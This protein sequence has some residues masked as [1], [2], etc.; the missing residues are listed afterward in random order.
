M[1]K[2]EAVSFLFFLITET[3][4]TKAWSFFIQVTKNPDIINF[5]MI[6]QH[7]T[8]LR[9]IASGFCID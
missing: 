6:W 5:K 7:I 9:L 2:Y 3:N 1:K 8:V 4:W